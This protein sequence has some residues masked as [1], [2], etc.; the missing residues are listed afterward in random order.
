MQVESKLEYG[1]TLNWDDKFTGTT[2][3]VLFMSDFGHVL[4]APTQDI[5]RVCEAHGFLIA[6]TRGGVCRGPELEGFM[7]EL[8]YPKKK[9]Q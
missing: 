5:R 2:G 6:E 1:V 3:A 8:E 9:E 4:L 7:S